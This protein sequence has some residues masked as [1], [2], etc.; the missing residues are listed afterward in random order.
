MGFWLTGFWHLLYN[1][2]YIIL[3]VMSVTSMAQPV[4]E[5]IDFPKE[6]EKILQLWKELNAFQTSLLQS[7]NR[8]RYLK[9]TLTSL[10]CWTNIL[11]MQRKS[12]VFYFEMHH[13]VFGINFQIHFI[14]LARLPVLFMKSSYKILLCK[15][16]YLHELNSWPEA[17]YD[18][19]VTADWHE[20]VVLQPTMWVSIAHANGQL[21]PQC[22]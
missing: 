6:E 15:N 1:I 17:L 9:V 2:I 22:S 18:V 14:S 7:K 13:L 19:E 10:L 21:V 12:Q 5:Q 11:Q 16:H 4:P 20:P 8:P 3:F